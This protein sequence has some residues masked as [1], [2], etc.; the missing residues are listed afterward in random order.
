M[1]L[2][3]IKYFLTLA[4]E[5]SFTKAAD[6][7][8][9]AQPPLSRQIKDLEEELDA[10]LF[11]RTKR[12]VVLT[13]AGERFR[14]YA[15]QIEHLSSQS[16]EVIKEMNKGL[17]GTLYLASV[18]GRA[19]HMMSEWVSDFHELYPNVEFNLWN[20]NSDDATSRLKNSLCDLAIIVGPYDQ[21]RLQGIHVYDEPWVAMIPVGHPVLDDIKKQNSKNIRDDEITL[22]SLA[23]YELIIPSRHSR[24]QEIT[25]WFEDKT[26]KPKVICRVAHML[27]AY[28]L[29][30]QKVGIAIYPASAAMYAS[31]DKV[32]IKK[33]I[34]PSVT[35]SYYLTKNVD[36]ELSLVADAFWKYVLEKASV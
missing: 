14:Q 34:N 31:D 23:P 17:Q 24:L 8:L 18:E 30:E 28:E 10:E 25:D 22:S 19:P 13:E 16:V 12:G 4:E 11:V 3:H 15:L 5:G 29:T 35:A 36:R 2:R 9:I 20:G 21:E 33:L 7:L 26:I 32:V 27:N 6:K 1:E